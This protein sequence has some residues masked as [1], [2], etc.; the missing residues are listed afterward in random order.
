M[1]AHRL[2][3]TTY[4]ERAEVPRELGAH[5]TRITLTE[6]IMS[7]MDCLEQQFCPSRDLVLQ[8]VCDGLSTMTKS[9]SFVL[10]LL[11]AL[12]TVAQSKEQLSP[13]LGSIEGTNTYV[14]RALRLRVTLPIESGTW[15]L[16]PPNKYA[17]NAHPAPSAD[18]SACRGPLCGKPEIETAL[19]TKSIPVQTLFVTCYKLQPEY[20][21]RQRYPLSKFA[22]AMLQGSLAGSDWVPQGEMTAAQLAGH[23]AYRLLVHDPSKP[24]KKGFGFVFESKAHM[25]VLVGTDVT[26]S[27]DLL[28]AVEA[29]TSD[30]TAKP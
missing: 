1:Q 2:T 10:L 23:Q 28:P 17:Q 9:V 21:N 6:E 12:A 8:V 15:N 13:L 22:E 26:A 3:A 29:A 14:N 25:C 20:L 7:V 30:K 5:S 16:M 27:Q 11:S 24:K 19:E 4:T 18:D